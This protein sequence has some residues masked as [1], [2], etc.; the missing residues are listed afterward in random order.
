M[1]NPVVPLMRLVGRRQSTKAWVDENGLSIL[2]VFSRH[3]KMEMRAYVQEHEGRPL[4]HLRLFARDKHGIGRPTKKG[5]AIET[6]DLPE[7]AEAVQALLV[8]SGSSSK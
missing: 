6:R 3:E 8:A 5:I 4:A 2:K 1:L 7:F